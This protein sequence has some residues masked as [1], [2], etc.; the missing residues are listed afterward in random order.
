[1][2][3][4]PLIDITVEIAPSDEMHYI[5]STMYMLTATSGAFVLEVIIEHSVCRRFSKIMLQQ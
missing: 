4:M 2:Q 1:M 5:A 3:Y